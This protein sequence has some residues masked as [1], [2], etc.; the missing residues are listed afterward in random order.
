MHNMQVEWDNELILVSEN[1]LK[2]FMH[3]VYTGMG[4][5][6]ISAL[7][8]L[9]GIVLTLVAMFFFVQNTPFFVAL[10]A[11]LIFNAFKLR[12]SY[13]NYRYGDYVIIALMNGF[14]EEKITKIMDEILHNPRDIP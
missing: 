13:R 2:S 6:L 1:N 4:A 9:A 8:F 11:F 7:T 12:R 3:I 5:S 10:W 14:G